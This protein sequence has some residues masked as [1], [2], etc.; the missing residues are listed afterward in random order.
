MPGVSPPSLAQRIPGPGLQGPDTVKFLEK[1]LVA[2]LAEVQNGT[3]SLSVFT[4][5][6]GGIVD[7]TV[8]TKVASL[9]VALLQW[10]QAADQRRPAGGRR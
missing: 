4:N 9:A 1:L 3:G 2:D 5:D 10:H 7:D 8:L 6:Q